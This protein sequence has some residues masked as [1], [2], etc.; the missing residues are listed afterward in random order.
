MAEPKSL[1]I[2]K[3]VSNRLKQI[4]VANGYNYNLGQNVIRG[5]PGEILTID[6]VPAV[7]VFSSIATG[8]DS[9]SKGIIVTSGFSVEVAMSDYWDDLPSNQVV[10]PEDAI[11]LIFQD[12]HQ[13]IEQPWDPVRQKDEIIGKFEFASDEPIRTREQS[14]VIGVRVDYTFSFRRNRGET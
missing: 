5:F 1:L 11:H 6:Q 3:E 10:E 2:I 12:V 8:T 9:K 4:S 14:S 13:A 7:F